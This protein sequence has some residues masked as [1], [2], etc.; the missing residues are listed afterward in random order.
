VKSAQ[1]EAQCASARPVHLR[2]Q[3]GHVVTLIYPR[4]RCRRVRIY[5][6]DNIPQEARAPS[7]APPWGN[8]NP[9]RLM[10]KDVAGWSQADLA[11]LASEYPQVMEE[12]RGQESAVL[13][14]RRTR[15][16]GWCSP[17]RTGN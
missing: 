13:E 9:E 15:T 16:Q 5:A 6:A 14:R 8:R 1:Q 10:L 4:S 7:N 3:S 12:L 2:P 17:E 11:R